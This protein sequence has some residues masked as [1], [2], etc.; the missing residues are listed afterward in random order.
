MHFKKKDHSVIVAASMVV[1]LVVCAFTP[2]VVTAISRANVSEAS[3]YNQYTDGTFESLNRD[4]V[5]EKTQEEWAAKKEAERIAAEEAQRKA[6]EEAA[7]LE[8]QQDSYDESYYDDEYDE[9]SYDEDYYDN[10]Y[11]ES[12]SSG[13][14]G[15]L[16]AA[17]GVNYYNGNMETW[18]SEKVLP[19]G[20]LDIPGRHVAEDG[21]VR[22][23]D[24]Y[25]VV[26]S[27]NYGYGS[28][29]ETSLGTGKVYDTGVGHDGWDIY[30]RW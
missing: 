22:D 20:G 3:L 29:V 5:D 8:A 4:Y 25:I 13:G 28:T 7:S 17:G 6:E 18:Y 19:G 9:N 2:V 15:V 21:T 26:A 30:T 23:A 1:V 14:S 27:D 24:G 11:D 16:T 12:Y 10:S